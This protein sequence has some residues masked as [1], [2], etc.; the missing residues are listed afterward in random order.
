M[1]LSKVNYLHPLE[2][3]LGQISASFPV[4]CIPFGAIQLSNL[5]VVE[6]LNFLL[7]LKLFKV[8]DD[9][10]VGLVFETTVTMVLDDKTSSSY[11]LIGARGTL[12]SEFWVP[13]FIQLGL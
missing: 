4:L 2:V 13:L 12:T 10:E 1:V 11:D 6:I 3:F 5:I 7:E 8:I 9:N